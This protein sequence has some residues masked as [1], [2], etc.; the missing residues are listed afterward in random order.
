MTIYDYTMVQD[1]VNLSVTNTERLAT[2]KQINDAADD[3]SNLSVALQFLSEANTT[4]Q[5]IQNSNSSLAMTNMADRAAQRQSD[6]LVQVNEKMIQASTATT[7]Q[8]G[9]D[10]I[11]QDI[12]GLMEQYDSI[13]SSTNYNGETLLQNSST[14]QSANESLVFQVGSDSNDDIYMNEIQLNTLGINMGS[15]FNEDSSTFTSS[16]AQQYVEKIS[17]AIDTTNDFRSEIGAT[18]VEIQSK[19]NSLMSDSTEIEL[20]K[21]ILMDVDYAKESM[22]FSKNNLMS[23]VGAFV[24]SQSANINQAS[25]T[26]L[27]T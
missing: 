13:A 2:S 3:G 18:A 25:V 22:N 19:T 1:Y 16:K 8:E 11:L 15:I 5:A 27:Y 17:K 21:S 20:S 12:Q 9:R 24:A 14:D 6:I 26:K 7:N 4:S 10:A 23:Q